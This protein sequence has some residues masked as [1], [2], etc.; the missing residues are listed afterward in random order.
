[1][2]VPYCVVAYRLTFN[3]LFASDFGPRLRESR[4][5][6]PLIV[7]PTLD[8]ATYLSWLDLRDACVCTALQRCASLRMPY[9][10]MFFFVSFEGLLGQ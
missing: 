4:L 8:S 6:D 1:M 9:F 10:V 7:L 5:K 2:W 3:I